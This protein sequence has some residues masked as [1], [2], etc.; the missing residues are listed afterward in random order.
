MVNRKLKTCPAKP[1]RPV[2]RSLGEGG[3]GIEN[4]KWSAFTLIELLV[5]IAIIALLV[6]I[7][8]PALSQA[9]TLTRIAQ[10][11][12][13]LKTIETGLEMFHDDR[14][15][16]DEYPVSGGT[17][18][19]V[20]SATIAIGD[21][22]GRTNEYYTGAE[23]LLWAMM[24]ADFHGT[25]GFDGDVGVD[26][27][28]L[29]ELDGSNNPVVARSGPFMNL[30]KTE[31]LKI[32][33]DVAGDINFN[34]GGRKTDGDGI[35][36][37]TIGDPFGGAVLYFRAT[38]R[39]ERIDPKTIYN[40]LHNDRFYV[41]HPLGNTT[42]AKNAGEPVTMNAFERFIWNPQ[43]KSYRPHNKDSFIL[44]LAGPDDEFGTIDDITN[45]PLEPKN[46]TAP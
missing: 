21:P 6:S 17:I 9:K 16:D 30:A 14:I 4:R 27:G 13:L 31:V 45:F 12:S 38:P 1:W 42:S 11:R 28:E 18:N 5:V 22:L 36:A 39:N 44:I 37:E 2:R 34:T 8:L 32:D 10:S 46:I 26:P 41:D 19:T 29:Y 35:L 7:L 3:S 33:D 20:T 15:G 40:R 43:I 23:T 24:G 25:P